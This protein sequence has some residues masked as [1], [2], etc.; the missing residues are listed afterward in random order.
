MSV[1]ARK[2]WPH[3]PWLSHENPEASVP[4]ILSMLIAA[5]VF[6]LLFVYVPICAKV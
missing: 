6:A 5:A 3:A 2:S 1:V 4:D